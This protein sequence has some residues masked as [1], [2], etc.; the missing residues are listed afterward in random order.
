[1]R[2]LSRS[3]AVVPGSACAIPPPR[4]TRRQQW[5]FERQHARSATHQTNDTGLTCADRN[6][7]SRR[8]S[9][10]VGP[11]PLTN[12]LRRLDASRRRHL[13]Q[14][15]TTH[16]DVSLLALARSHA[17][18]ATVPPDRPTTVLSP[19][20]RSSGFRAR[21]APTC[22]RSARSCGGLRADPAGESV[23]VVLSSPE[24]RPALSCVLSRFFQ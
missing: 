23:A 6:T 21:R 8:R 4:P 16:P 24:G 5:A 14:Q 20:R 17:Q 15:T 12:A 18:P 7:P 3:S 2:G 13:Q 22:S 19:P 9:D 10:R 1:M 11:A